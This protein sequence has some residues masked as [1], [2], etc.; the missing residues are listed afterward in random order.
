MMNFD[1]N[2]RSIPLSPLADP[3]V[4]AIFAN[5]DV[6]GRAAESLIRAILGADNDDALIGRVI[7]VTPQ[8]T[9]SNPYE[10]G[11]RIDVETETDANERPVFEIQINPDANMATRNLFSASRI[12]TETSVKGDKIHHLALR[13]PRVIFINI[14]GYNIREDNMDVVQPIKVLYTK[15]PQRTAI[16][17][18]SG[19]NVQLPRLLEAKPNFN[20]PLYCWGYTLYTAHIQN[21]SI[22]EVIDM[23]PELQSYTR[24]DE[25]YQQFCEQ[26]SLVAADPQSRSDYFRWVAAVMRHE[27]EMEAAR[28]IGMEKGIAE[29]MEK[30][31]QKLLELLKSGL[32]PDEAY[33]KLLGT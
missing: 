22:K 10:R 12:F 14:L 21:K 31:A 33:Q 32:S 5:V 1:P 11:C 19:Y 24:Q 9:H 20:D 4:G 23:T 7:R 17:Y 25:G 30:G 8:N 27:G 15:P 29:G 26:Y 28:Q 18:F 6:A 13:M 3:V 16:P 2:D